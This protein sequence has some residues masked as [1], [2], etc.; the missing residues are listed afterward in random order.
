M[1]GSQ[2]HDDVLVAL[3]DDGTSVLEVN[4]GVQWGYVF[5]RFVGRCQIIQE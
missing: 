1:N 5:G 4:E 3:N 2:A